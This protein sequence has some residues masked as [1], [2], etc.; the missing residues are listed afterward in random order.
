M[1]IKPA[2]KRTGS[3]FDIEKWRGFLVNFL[4]V[5]HFQLHYQGE[6]NMHQIVV[7]LVARAIRNAIRASRFARI[8]RN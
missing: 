8:I 3:G 4:A 6:P 7:T 5:L 1:L 2:L